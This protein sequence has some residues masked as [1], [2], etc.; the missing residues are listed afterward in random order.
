[1]RKKNT[2]FTLPWW[3]VVVGYILCSLCIANGVW[4]PYLYSLDWG[5]E[6]A[7]EWLASLIVSLFQSI[8]VIQ[9]IKVSSK[10]GLFWVSFESSRSLALINLLWSLQQQRPQSHNGKHHFIKLHLDCK[11][12]QLGLSKADFTHLH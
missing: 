12:V 8:I 9:P 7:L 10:S 6:V 3:G 5:K 11:Y 2:P 4:W 1:M